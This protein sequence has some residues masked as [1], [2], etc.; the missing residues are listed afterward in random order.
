[1][2][3]SVN[4][5]LKF[6]AKTANTDGIPM[7]DVRGL[8]PDDRVD[9]MI[10]RLVMRGGYKKIVHGVKDEVYQLDTTYYSALGCNDKKM[11]LARAI[12]MFMPGK[13]QVWYVDLLA[14]P[15]YEEVLSNNP[16][17]DTR[18]VNRKRFTLK[19]A[20]DLIKKPIVKKQL[21]LLKLRNTHP[22]FSEEATIEITRS[23][24]SDLSITWTNKDKYAS[25]SIDFKKSD[26]TITKN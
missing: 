19:E 2:S 5:A 7:R 25:I 10:E 12:Q 4:N 26:Y 6:S 3:Y 24:E 17:A 18:E 14:E 9:E 23:G 16:E 21:E 15:N 8:L 22:S 20:H 1:M 13:P 11:E